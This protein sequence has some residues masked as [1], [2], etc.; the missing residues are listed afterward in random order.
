[1]TVK[2]TYTENLQRHI[3]LHSI[4]V[5]EGPLTQVLTCVFQQF[6]NL[7]HYV[8]DD[9]NRL[10]KHVMLVVDNNIVQSDIESVDQV[11][12]SLHIMQALSGG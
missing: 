1:M 8:L 5:D 7:K 10:R 9:Q 4:Q 11:K 3:D 12:S 6:P 2:V